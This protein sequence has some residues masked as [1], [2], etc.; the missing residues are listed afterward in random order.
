MFFSICSLQS[1]F[2]M[3]S[4]VIHE[5]SNSSTS[6]HIIFTSKNMEQLKFL[7][8]ALII[9]DLSIILACSA[10]QALAFA[11]F[12]MSFLCL[13]SAIIFA[14]DCVPVT[15]EYSDAY[16]PH[17][18]VSNEMMRWSG[19][20]TVTETHLYDDSIPLWRQLF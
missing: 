8:K 15:S 12:A 19:C 9:N 3:H 1:C 4:T 5:M 17:I 16:E 14:V 10:M 11:F 18:Q 13:N 20:S 7:H 6:H 2:P